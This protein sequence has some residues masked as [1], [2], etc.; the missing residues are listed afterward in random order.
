M[1]SKKTFSVGGEQKEL[2]FSFAIQQRLFGQFSVDKF[3]EALLDPAFTIRALGF[4]LI[5]KEFGA[6]KTVEEALDRFEEMNLTDDESHEI[7]N[8]VRERVLNF[9]QKEIET[10]KRQVQQLLPHLQMPVN[11]APESTNS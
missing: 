1:D 2:F 6:I 10:V 3:Q 5:G 4:L 7:M 11:P 8:W 9:T